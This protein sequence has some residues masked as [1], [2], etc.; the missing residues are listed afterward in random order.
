MAEIL[1]ETKTIR[2]IVTQIEVTLLLLDYFY[3]LNQQL[4]DL[5][6][7]EGCNPNVH[8]FMVILN[9]MNEGFKIVVHDR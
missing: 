5:V 3:Q 9:A 2:K 4:L 6:V 8:S 7:N 1:D